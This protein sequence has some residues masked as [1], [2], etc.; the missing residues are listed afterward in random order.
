VRPNRVA[1]KYHDFKKDV[2]LDA[3]VRVFNYVMD[4]NAETS[5][6]ISLMR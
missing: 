3:H 1:L 4:G 2:D 6:K 5:E